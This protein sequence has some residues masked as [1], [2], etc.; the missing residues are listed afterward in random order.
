[1]SKVIKVN[2]YDKCAEDFTETFVNPEKISFLTTI[3]EEGTTF[4]MVYLEDLALR[5]TPSSYVGLVRILYGED[6][7]LQKPRL[8]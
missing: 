8:Y 5:L 6:Y 7:D 1:M 3:K 4:Y 2:A